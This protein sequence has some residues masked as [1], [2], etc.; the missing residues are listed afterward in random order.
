VRP[1]L[2]PA[3]SR[4]SFHARAPEASDAEIELAWDCD[5][6][7]GGVAQHDV[8]LRDEDLFVLAGRFVF[9]PEASD[10]FVRLVEPA[11]TFS[12]ATTNAEGGAFELSLSRGGPLVLDLGRGLF[13]RGLF[14]QPIELAPG[15]TE[16]SAEVLSAELEVTGELP[17][18]PDGR[19]PRVAYR[20]RGAN[21]LDFLGGWYSPWKERVPA[22]KGELVWI[23]G[24]DVRAEA[25]VLRTL[26]LA[27]GTTTV[28]DLDQPR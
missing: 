27:P 28:V 11:S 8:D 4:Q 3:A 15:R 1:C 9:G 17:R 10:W 24:G 12:L 2:P 23:P 25:T 22:G 20:W 26:D 13:S 14:R 5:V 18:E 6:R 7:P 21:G 19:I 16:W